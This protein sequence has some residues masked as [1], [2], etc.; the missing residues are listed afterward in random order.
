L[1]QILFGARQMKKIEQVL[2]NLILELRTL[3]AR[4][5]YKISGFLTYLE[6]S[7]RIKAVTNNYNDNTKQKSKS[8]KRDK[9]KR[10]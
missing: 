10:S 6:M 9:Y 3:I 1:R 4:T 2:A 5:A 8:S 7:L